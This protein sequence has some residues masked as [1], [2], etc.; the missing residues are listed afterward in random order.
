[1][2]AP[3]PDFYTLIHKAIRL[4]MSEFLIVIGSTDPAD[5]AGWKIASHRWSQIKRLLDAH[6]LHED[7]HVHPLIRRVAPDVADR[8]DE[9][10]EELDEQIRAID[11][12]MSS[13][14]PSA[15]AGASR[16]AGRDVYQRFSGFV[17]SYFVHLIEEENEA[18]PALVAQVPTEELLAAHHQ[19]IGSMPPEERLGDLPF[20]A[21]SLSSPERIALMTATQAGAPPAFFAEACR[22]MEEAIGSS[23]FAPVAAALRDKAA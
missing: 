21:R 12:M 9:Q 10:H 19:L 2:S 20:V 13:I 7:T 16:R 8:L 15:D 23:A 3:A 14:Q 11:A 18:M 4:A 6:S 17:A 1:M 22:I 5:A